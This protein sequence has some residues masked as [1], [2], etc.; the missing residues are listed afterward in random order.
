MNEMLLN[1]NLIDL[2]LEYTEVSYLCKCT[3]SMMIEHKK[4]FFKVAKYEIK[5]IDRDA[6]SMKEKSKGILKDIY[7]DKNFNK[8]LTR[9]FLRTIVGF[10][11]HSTINDDH[12]KAIK[13]S[14]NFDLYNDYDRLMENFWAD[15]VLS[16]PVIE[17]ISL[18]LTD[19][20]HVKDRRKI[21]DNLLSTRFAKLR[22][23]NNFFKGNV[24]DVKIAV[25]FDKKKYKKKFNI[26]DFAHRYRREAKIRHRQNELEFQRPLRVKIKDDGDLKVFKKNILFHQYKISKSLMITQQFDYQGFLED[27]AMEAQPMKKLRLYQLSP[28]L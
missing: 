25:D 22:V 10:V 3:Q 2:G 27:N 19:I 6:Y 11:N 16:R 26:E 28:E 7:H 24:A 12:W 4:D 15:K 9:M 14:Y 18:R 8:P 20:E 21:F 23:L 1:Q 17:I 5:D 13:N